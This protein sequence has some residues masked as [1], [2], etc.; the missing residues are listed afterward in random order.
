MRV[1]LA[2][3]D[4]AEAAAMVLR[5]SIAELCTADHNDD[6]AL[7]GPWLANKTPEIFRS[8]LD[9]P[10]NT[11]VVAVDENGRLLGVGASNGMGEITLNYVSPDARFAGVS[12]A[13]MAD[14]ENRLRQNGLDV[15]RLTSTRTAH[16]FY[17]A[18]GYRDDGV[19]VA[20]RGGVLAQP[21]VKVL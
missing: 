12:S 10:G 5:R 20:S 15:S 7:V 19:V 14:L 1:R 11:V 18:R 4:D 9:E 16:R 2:A 8:W 6:P 13:L 21:M 17:L 3:P